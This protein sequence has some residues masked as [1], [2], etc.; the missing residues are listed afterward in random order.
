MIE[1]TLL[2]PI[3]VLSYLLWRADRRMDVALKEWALERGAL[4]QRIQ[5]PERAVIEDYEPDP[6]SHGIPFDDDAA[7]HAVRDLMSE[8]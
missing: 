8:N 4:L 1:L 5:A 3:A 2:A 6:R 7:F